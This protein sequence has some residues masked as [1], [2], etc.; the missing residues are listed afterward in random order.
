MTGAGGDVLFIEATGRWSG[1]PGLTLTGQLGDV[2]KESAPIALSYLRSHGPAPG[3]LA[4]RKLHVHVPGG[5][6]P[7]GRAER[8][9]HDDDGAGVAAV[10]ASRQVDR[11]HDR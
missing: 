9:R 4:S 11:R 3:D 5:R 7:Q 6:G 1:D 2:M 8:G 10:G